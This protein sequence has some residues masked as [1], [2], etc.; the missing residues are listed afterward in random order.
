M[1]YNYNDFMNKCSIVVKEF[2][3]D[4][5]KIFHHLIIKFGDRNNTDTLLKQ[6]LLL[7]GV[8]HRNR[9]INNPFSEKSSELINNYFDINEIKPCTEQEG[10]LAYQIFSYNQGYKVLLLVANGC[11]VL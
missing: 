10:K 1:K 4:A 8:V 5:F 11:V 6:S 7:S 9:F 3:L 2:L